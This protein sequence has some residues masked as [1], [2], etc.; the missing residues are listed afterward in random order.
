MDEHAER[1]AHCDD[2]EG[3]RLV[4][5]GDERISEKRHDDDDVVEDRRDGSRQVVP[6]GVEQSRNN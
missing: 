3:E 2:V 1:V 6:V 4:R 5:G